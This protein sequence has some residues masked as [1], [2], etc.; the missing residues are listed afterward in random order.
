MGASLSPAPGS[1]PELPPPMGNRRGPSL[2]SRQGPQPGGGKPA[3][4]QQGHTAPN[5]QASTVSAHGPQQVP[6]TGTQLAEDIKYN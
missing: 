2:K 5:T 3:L 1:L 6:T 4:N